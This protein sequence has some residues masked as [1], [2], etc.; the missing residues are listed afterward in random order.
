VSAL[1]LGDRDHERRLAVFPRRRLLRGVFRR[2]HH[3][4]AAGSVHVHHPHAERR[5]GSDG[6]RDRVGDVVKFQIQE[7]AVAPIGER[8]DDR[9]P[10]GREQAAADLESARDVPQRRGE[11]QRAGAA[12]HVQRNQELIHACSFFVVLS[13][14]VSS[15]SRA[16]PW[17]VM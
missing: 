12:L 17:R 3:A 2:P 9:R 15:D 6:R 14:P 11:L 4:R 8:A 1:K 7:D 5:R 10:F 16:T 13:V